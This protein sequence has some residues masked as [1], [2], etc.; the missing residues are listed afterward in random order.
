MRCQKCG[1]QEKNWAQEYCRQCG[2]LFGGAIL[3][4]VIAGA[5]CISLGIFLFF[6]R[7]EV[8]GPLLFSTVGVSIFLRLFG[9]LRKASQLRNAGNNKAGN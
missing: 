7:S 8:V 2:A 1:A 9:K 3:V 4:D 6:N 5:G